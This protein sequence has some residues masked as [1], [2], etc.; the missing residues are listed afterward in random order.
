MGI[1]LRCNSHWHTHINQGCPTV[2]PHAV[3]KCLHF[4]G[5]SPQLSDHICITHH[6]QRAGDREQH[7]E[8]VDCE[9]T[10]L[11]GLVAV[12]KSHVGHIVAVHNGEGLLQGQKRV[13]NNLKVV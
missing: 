10:A 13:T 7:H 6:H 11:L 1:S 12:V 8:L 2:S 4:P 5:A 3:C 9:L